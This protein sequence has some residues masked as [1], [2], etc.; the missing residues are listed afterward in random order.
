[1]P[2]RDYNL[3][4]E[5]MLDAIEAISSYTNGLDIKRFIDDRKTVDAVIRNLE[6]LG[7]AA[8]QVPESS[9]DKSDKIDWRGMIGLRNRLI[10]GY[11][12]VDEN[13]LWQIIRDDIPDLKSQLIELQSKLMPRQLNEF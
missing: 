1:M 2:K 7:E 3:F 5:D 4:L 10:Q 12:D 9:K 11:F 6:I 8:S 13:I